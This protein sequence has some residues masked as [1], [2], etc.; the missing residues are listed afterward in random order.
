MVV[1]GIDSIRVGNLVDSLRPVLMAPAE[2]RRVE[3]WYA[4]K[5]GWIDQFADPQNVFFSAEVIFEEYLLEGQLANAAR[6]KT[7]IGRLYAKDGNYA[8]AIEAGQEAFK[9]AQQSMDS[10]ALGWSLTAISN[11][12]FAMRD[13]EG[14]RSYGRK[15][16]T[17]KPDN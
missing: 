4:N 10:V 1:A 13:L 11:I 12:F 3:N 9:L 7:A 17:L 8:T 2:E 16:F 6:A 15:S 5:S 14:A